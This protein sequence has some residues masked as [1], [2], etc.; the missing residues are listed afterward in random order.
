MM[1]RLALTPLLLLPALAPP[2]RAVPIARTTRD[3]A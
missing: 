3:D 1:R 2:A